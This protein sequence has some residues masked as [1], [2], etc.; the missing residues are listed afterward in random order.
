MIMFFIQTWASIRICAVLQ[1]AI[2]KHTK[3]AENVLEAL[4]WDLKA[5]LQSLRPQQYVVSVRVAEFKRER[6]RETLE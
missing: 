3:N 6:E 4:A 2:G 5:L 1:S